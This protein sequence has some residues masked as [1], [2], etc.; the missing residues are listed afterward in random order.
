MGGGG[1]VLFG[2]LLSVRDCLLLARTHVSQHRKHEA[3]II[4][5]KTLFPIAPS[6]R[7][8][9]SPRS[10]LQCMLFMSTLKV[11][12]S[13]YLFYCRLMWHKIHKRVNN[14]R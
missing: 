6:W 3:I 10:K 4:N 5:R 1:V 2:C 14:N 11:H 13:D 7:D 12:Q 9:V 8:M